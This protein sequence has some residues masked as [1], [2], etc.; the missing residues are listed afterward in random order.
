LSLLGFSLCAGPRNTGATVKAGP[1]ELKAYT[2][3]VA[4]G[5][6]RQESNDGETQIAVLT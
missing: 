1:A 3:F 5:S 2:R 4:I 6:R